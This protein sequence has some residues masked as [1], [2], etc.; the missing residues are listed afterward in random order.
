MF[1]NNLIIRRLQEGNAPVE[2]IEE[3]KAADDDMLFNLINLARLIWKKE[4]PCSSEVEKLIHEIIKETGGQTIAA[5]LKS[6][7]NAFP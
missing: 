5:L 6:I 2:L 3:I 7:T 4:R 1:R